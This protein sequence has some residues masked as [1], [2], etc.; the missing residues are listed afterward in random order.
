VNAT[1]EN[2]AGV[3]SR[4]PVEIARVL[5]GIMRRHSL[6]AVY[7]AAA[8]FR[9]MLRDVD[10]SVGRIVVERSP[11]SAANAALLSRPRATFHCEIP[12]WHVEFVAAEPRATLHDGAQAIECR[13]PE[14][15][16]SYQ[17]REHDRIAIRPPLP[18]RVLADAAGFTP[19]GASVVDVAAGGVGFIVYSQTINLE[20]GTVLRGSRIELPDGGVCAVD[21]EVRHSEAVNFASGTRAM[22]SGCRFVG[23][24]PELI[25]L[26]KRY[27][28]AG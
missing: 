27:I 7:G 1:L 13:F 8:V 22:R 12:G 11:D 20:P 10:S 6:L 21:L 26:V 17:R 9:S 3:V 19:F 18:L 4:S 28:G 25:A 5:E 15:L 2:R 16:S 24:T 23:P 14:L